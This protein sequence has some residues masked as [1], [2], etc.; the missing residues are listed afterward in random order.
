MATAVGAFIASGK[1]SK[2][3]LC[4]K[5]FVFQW[6]PSLEVE[7]PAALLL[8]VTRCSIFSNS[9]IILPRWAS[10]GVTHSYSKRPFLCALY[11]VVPK[12]LYFSTSGLGMRL[13]VH[14]NSNIIEE[15]CQEFWHQKLVWNVT[16]LQFW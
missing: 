9:S 14:L 6:Y 5:D 16:V 11:S 15:I 13:K 8:H 2:K 7:V 4:A 3:V 1:V 10:I 12:P